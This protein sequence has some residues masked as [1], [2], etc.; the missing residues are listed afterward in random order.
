MSARE[1]CAFCKHW[2]QAPNGEGGRCHLNPPTT[3]PMLLPD[4]EGNPVL[5]FFTSWPKT[6]GDEHCAQWAIRLLVS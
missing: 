6:R 1:G 4:E 2:E 3:F 5:R